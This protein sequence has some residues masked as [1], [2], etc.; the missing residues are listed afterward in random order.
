MVK[1][2]KEAYVPLMTYDLGYEE[3][4][5]QLIRSLDCLDK[6]VD[7]VYEHVRGKV[8][9]QKS[10]IV[11]LNDRLNAVADKVDRLSNTKKSVRIY[12]GAK[13]P[14]TD[15]REHYDCGYDFDV[16]SDIVENIRVV[17]RICTSRDPSDKLKFYHVDDDGRRKIS[18][19]ANPVTKGLGGLPDDV[20]HVNSLLLFNSNENLYKNYV[21]SNPY[22]AN[23]TT[24][25]KND[26]EN[27]VVEKNVNK[28][29][30]TLP[31][32]DAENLFD[33][34]YTP[35]YE[36]V[37]SIDVPADL[38]DLPG[39]A[40]DDVQCFNN[41]VEEK[42]VDA[43]VITAEPLPSPIVV[44]R[45]PGLDELDDFQDDTGT[46][47][48]REE[49]AVQP[50]IESEPAA[51]RPS[52]IVTNAEP[53]VRSDD[54]GDIAVKNDD[55]DKTRREDLNTHSV[56]MDEIRNA[57]G[58]KK[59]KLRSVSDRITDR[60]K[61]PTGDGLMADLHKKLAM[62]RQGISGGNKQN[63]SSL[64]GVIYRMASTMLPPEPDSESEPDGNDDTEG[65]WDD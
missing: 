13:Y 26:V 39:I 30:F 50:E 62:R 65:D 1:V 10:E 16:R 60:E 47:A 56:L 33:L 58:L 6:V 42:P 17:H 12:S 49:T 31:L 64:E 37:P 19:S 2:N 43:A 40:A 54:V 18:Q 44:D 57:G 53:V 45:R 61:V 46:A 29:V 9:S 34:T 22:K 27:V 35:S 25:S 24:A 21:L 14:A 51:E 11:K 7:R 15:R 48:A 59:A 8:N 36:E 32:N 23:V 55:R 41:N 63:D 52:S 38:P 28:S 20:K 5:L 3:T 4:V